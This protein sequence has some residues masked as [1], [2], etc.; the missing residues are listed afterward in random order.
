ML[1]KLE[2]YQNTQNIKT[3][4]IWGLAGE[5]F[6]D[7]DSVLKFPRSQSDW[8]SME[9]NL[10]TIPKGSAAN[11]L[12]LDTNAHPPRNPLE[13][14]PKGPELQPAAQETY[15]MLGIMFLHFTV[16]D[17]WCIYIFSRRL[18]SHLQLDID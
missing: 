14:C 5:E 18:Y 10:L 15:T 4:R 17:D 13:W 16:M 8:A 11:F 7:V 1:A 6:T 3:C 12:M 2:S 9:C